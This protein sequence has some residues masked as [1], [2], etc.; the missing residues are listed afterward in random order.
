M[1][2]LDAL[3][4]D[5]TD[6]NGSTLLR[7]GFVAMFFLDGVHAS[8]AVSVADTMRRFVSQFMDGAPLFYPSGDSFKE[9][10]AEDA[11][12]LLEREVMVP[13]APPRFALLDSAT[14][15]PR[16]AAAYCGLDREALAGRHWPHA[17][18][19]LHFVF[20]LESMGEH[21]LRQIFEFASLCARA[22]P[23]V[24]G[25]VSPAFV[26]DVPACAETRAAA[27]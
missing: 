18:C 4:L 27:G 12:A 5:L 2:L 17:I 6:A 24:S 26:G 23:L 25:Y 16:F 13:L 21:G 1:P 7:A 10:R 19:G 8:H 11:T 15:A 3:S 14:D 20:D 22:L 9:V